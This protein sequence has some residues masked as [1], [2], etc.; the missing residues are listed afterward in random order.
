MGHLHTTSVDAWMN[1]V[2]YEL[3]AAS[4]VDAFDRA[5]SKLW[6]R[7]QRTLSAATLTTIVGRV[8]I[9]AVAKVPLLGAL[10]IEGGELRCDEL[11][12]HAATIPRDQLADGLRFLLVELLTVVGGLTAEVMTPPLH[13]ELAGVGRLHLV[14]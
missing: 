9:D 12:K 8:L 7:A 10:Y 1:R 11:R 3:P 5:F 13:A 14:C 6:S 4:L 2:A